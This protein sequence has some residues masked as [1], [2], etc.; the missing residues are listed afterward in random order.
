MRDVRALE[1]HRFRRE[2][3]QIRRLNLYPSTAS[4]RIRALLVGKDRI[5]FGFRCAAMAFSGHALNQR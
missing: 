4:E 1:N 2:L 5:K 3:V